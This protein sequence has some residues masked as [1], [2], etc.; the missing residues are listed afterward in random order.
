VGLCVHHITFTFVDMFDTLGTIA[1][2]AA[3]LN[4]L[5]EDGSFE[6]ADRAL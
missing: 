2:L 4:I 6:G 1:G 5:K 3:K